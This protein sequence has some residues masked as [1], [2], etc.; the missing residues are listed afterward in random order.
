MLLPTA[1]FDSVDL[2]SIQTKKIFKF[3]FRFL[4]VN[5]RFYCFS[6]YPESHHVNSIIRKWLQKFPVFLLI[7]KR[8]ELNSALFYKIKQN[9]LAS[10]CCI[11]RYTRKWH[12]RHI[13]HSI[14]GGATTDE[15][16][17][18]CLAMNERRSSGS[19]IITSDTFASRVI[20]H[21]HRHLLLL[22]LV[23]MVVMMVWSVAGDDGVNDETHQFFD[24]F[25][26]RA[27][28]A[29]RHTTAGRIVATVNQQRRRQVN[30]IGCGV[31]FHLT[32]YLF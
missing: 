12:S 21:R 18:H 17:S 10:C 2:Y 31:L 8:L 26:R 25:N 13:H 32:C 3:H 11:G 1:T 5:C 24:V 27:R 14:S 30:D 4:F 16:L 29:W 7:A 6:T 15:R 19:Q 23:I 20:V 28:R 22:L 9:Q